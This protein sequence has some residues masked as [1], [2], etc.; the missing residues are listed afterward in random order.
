MKRLQPDTQLQLDLF[1]ME[2]QRKP[3]RIIRYGDDR[4]R[5]S[6]GHYTSDSNN[7]GSTEDRLREQLQVLRI[8]CSIW[9]NNRDKEIERLNKE[10]KKY[11][12]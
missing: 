9:L 2:E 8:N 3:N 4:S 1:Q 11:T 6:E 12:E 10:L 5:D 7:D